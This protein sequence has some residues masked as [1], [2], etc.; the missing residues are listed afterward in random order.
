[1]RM[2]LAIAFVIMAFGAMEAS[3]QTVEGMSPQRDAQKATCQ[4]EAQL[5]YRN[6]RNPSGEW[7][8]QVSQTRKVYV[9][10]CMAKAGFSPVS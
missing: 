8:A 1:M 7:R 4:K 5:I 10:E 2:V 3:A 6:G 9:Q